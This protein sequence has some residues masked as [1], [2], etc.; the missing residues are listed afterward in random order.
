MVISHCEK[1]KKIQLPK[2]GKEIM[3]Y[4]QSLAIWLAMKSMVARIANQ[5]QPE[6]EF[7]PFNL[8]PV[9]LEPTKEARQ[10]VAVPAS[11]SEALPLRV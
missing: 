8:P 10:P 11:S 3:E 2:R 7:V 4:T 9:K 5:S 1:S 6:E